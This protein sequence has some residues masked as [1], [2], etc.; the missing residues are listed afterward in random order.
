MDEKALIIKYSKDVPGM[1][2]LFQV[3]NWLH[4]VTKDGLEMHTYLYPASN[5]KCVVISLHGLGSYSQPSGLIAKTLADAGCE[6]VAFDFRGHGK[7]QGIRGFIN[8]VDDLVQD[9]LDFLLEIKKLYKDLPIF[10]MGGSIGGAVTINVSIL[11]HS[12]IAGIILINPAI[13]INSRFEGCIRGISNCLASC[14]P[15]MPVYKGDLWSTSKN[16][17]LHKYWDENPYFYNGKVRIGTSAAVMNAMKS[18]RSKYHLVQNR[19]LLIQGTDDRITSVKKVNSFM[20]KVEVQDKTL[21]MYPGRPHSIVF[22]DAVYEI[23][24]KI[25]DWVVERL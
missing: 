1:S 13:G 24:A 18:L 10:L 21:L 14:C 12:R 7:S 9:T 20:K 4:F 3:E 11:A 25:R 19:L 8:S 5:A 2:V 17:T 6:V 15:T 23:A 22:E 16:E